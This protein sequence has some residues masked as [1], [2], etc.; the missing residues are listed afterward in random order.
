MADNKDEEHL[1]NPKNLQ[2]ENLSDKI[3]AITDTEAINPNQE[4]KNM[5][6][7]HHPDLHHKP[8]KWKEYFLEFLMIFLAVT[9]GFF[10]ES[11]RENLLEKERVHGYMREIVE[12]LKYDTTR[13]NR[14]YRSN[15]EIFLG[16]D[17]LRDELKQA[18][19][20]QINGN[21]LYYLEKKYSADLAGVVF[22]TS[23]ITELKS[24]GSLRLVANKKLVEEM[25]DYYE[26][27]IT[28][29]LKALPTAESTSA[30]N[31]RLNDFFKWQYFDKYIKGA[32][33]L[34]FSSEYNFE[35]I[36]TRNPPL[37]LLKSKPE[38]LETLYNIISLREYQLKQFC[39]YL[40]WAKEPAV[41]LIIDI[42]KE[43]HLE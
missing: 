1:D 39:S 42:R 27:R 33:T 17:S 26:R 10:A 36:L 30:L 25:S 3:I 21:K 40:T 16:M 6:V 29:V 18:M 15:Q 19:N 4:S 32:D 8:K 2:S 5:E 22:N 43:Y 34:G 13:I 24:S 31:T 12:N 28:S 20:G 41:K 37:Q 7:H 14:N 23:A 38:E 35:E 9:L 11:L